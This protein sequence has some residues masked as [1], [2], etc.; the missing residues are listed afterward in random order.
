ML[1]T[2]TK[3]DNH[4]CYVPAALPKKARKKFVFFD[5]ETRKDEC[6]RHVVNYAVAQTVFEKCIHRPSEDDGPCHC[7]RQ[8]K[9]C[10]KVSSNKW[11]HNYVKPPCERTCGDRTFHFAGDDVINQFCIWLVAPQNK[12]IIAVAHNMKAYDG[13][14]VYVYLSAEKWIRRRGH[15]QR[16]QVHANTRQRLPNHLPG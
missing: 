15:H 2:V 12:D 1:Q 9:A 5:F 10:D 13:V 7:G 8:C 14:F 11:K 16:V 3:G 6:K 4:L